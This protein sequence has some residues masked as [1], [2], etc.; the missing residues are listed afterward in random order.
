MRPTT[1]RW[2]GQPSA[3]ASVAVG[4]LILEGLAAHRLISRGESAIYTRARMERR[5]KSGP[6]NF[7]Y[8]LELE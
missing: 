1:V 3:A 6:G 4:E 5:G 7:P 8:G 2:S